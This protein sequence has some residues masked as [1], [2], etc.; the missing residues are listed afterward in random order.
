VPVL[1]H[2]PGSQSRAE[3]Q[4]RRDG[5]LLAPPFGGE[6]LKVADAREVSALMATVPS[7]TRK[8]VIVIG[9]M[10]RANNNAADALL[11]LIEEIDTSLFALNLWAHDSGG[12]IATIRSRCDLVWCPHA[13]EPDE[14]ED[15]S[16]DEHA[17]SILEGRLG[18]NPIMVLEHLLAVEDYPRLLESLSE[19]L[20]SRA[21]SD[22]FDMDLWDRLRELHPQPTQT[23]L[24]VAVMP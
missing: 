8:G 12:V 21:T 22:D 7:G 5:R 2:G 11:K 4:A 24:L 6:G 16:L 19:R 9:P 15:D 20:A 3:I 17:N 1:F 23:E 18:D 13:P 14:D 10:D